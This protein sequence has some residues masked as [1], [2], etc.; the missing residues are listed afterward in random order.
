[1]GI[2]CPNNNNENPNPELKPP[3]NDLN[4]NQTPDQFLCSL[5]ATVPE[6]LKIHSDSGIIEF[7]C[8]EHGVMKLPIDKYIEKIRNS[9][10]YCPN[11]KCDN[12]KCN[13]KNT[14]QKFKF[15]QVCENKSL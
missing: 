1:M 6:I 2:F 9:P 15:C 5:C 14:E 13:T 12:I 11:L 8:F 3:L 10:F 7:K 4:M